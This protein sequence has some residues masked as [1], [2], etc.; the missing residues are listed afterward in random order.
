MSML[1][2]CFRRRGRGRRDHGDS[3][4]RFRDV[5]CFHTFESY[6]EIL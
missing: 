6:F 5:S 1:W 4:D 3:R 2:T